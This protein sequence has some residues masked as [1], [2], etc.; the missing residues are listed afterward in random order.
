MK[1]SRSQKTPPGGK[2]KGGVKLCEEVDKLISTAVF[3]L[4]CI[5]GS[6]PHVVYV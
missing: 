1:G 4:L 6:N 2:K 3:V 5:G